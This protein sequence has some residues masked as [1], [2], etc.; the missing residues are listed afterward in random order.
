MHSKCVQLFIF[1]E[2]VIDQCLILAH[3]FIKS[4]LKVKAY[5]LKYLVVVW[6]V[7]MDRGT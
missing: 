2:I 1:L 6:L 4:F 5:I 3:A 7:V